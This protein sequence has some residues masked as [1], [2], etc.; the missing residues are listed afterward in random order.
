MNILDKSAKRE[1][2]S[3]QLC[4]TMCARDAIKI[5]LNDDGFYRPV[6]DA[7][8]CTDCGLCAKICY[9][10][11]EELKITTPE[12]LAN[13]QLYS[14]WSNNDELVR[15]TTSGGIGDLLAHELLSQGYKVVGCV[16]NDEKV[17][18]EHR[19]AT[20][21]EKLIPFRGSKYIQS[22][23]F[24]AFKEVVKNCKKEKYAVF[25]TPCQ[26]YALSR[27][28][29]IK[30]VR[31]QF[32]FVDLYCHGCPSLHVWTKYHDYIKKTKKLDH[33]DHVE[34]RSKVAGWGTFYVV[35]VVVDGKLVFKSKKNLSGFYELFFC[36]QV[37][38]D[39]CAGCLLRGTLAY[40]DIRIGDFWG[41]KYLKNT[42]G[43]SG[44]SVVTDRG[45]KLFNKVMKNDITATLCDYKDFLPYQSYGKFYHPRPA[46][47]LAILKSLKDNN[48]DVWD[49]VR[50]LHA[51]Q[52]FKARLTRY[53][54]NILALFPITVTNAI[55]K[56]M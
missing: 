7:D 13:T 42:R 6:V 51:T 32:V 37:L 36:D 49:A 22:Y 2:T 4:A 56:F 46:A 26:I 12:Q 27:I 31:D 3:C 21:E 38:N 35:A 48:K 10:F 15:N 41:K 9:R 20:T 40:T 53:A 8:K 14:A 28:A 39:A 25:G 54:K 19:I 47:R 18:A 23:N 17:R 16:Y 5:I 45:I 55:K 33:F 43:V 1:C 34:F 29:E 11:D 30:K 52:P 24:D 44:V 50:V